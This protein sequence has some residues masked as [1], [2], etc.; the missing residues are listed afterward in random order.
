MAVA[1]LVLLMCGMRQKRQLTNHGNV[2]GF[3]SAM[4]LILLR[5]LE[6]ALLRD[7]DIV[8]GGVW[9]DGDP[10]VLV[11]VTHFSDT[12]MA[13]EEG[14]R[15]REESD[16]KKQESRERES[17][18]TGQK[19]GCPPRLS[20]PAGWEN[21]TAAGWYVHWHRCTADKQLVRFLRNLAIICPVAAQRSIGLTNVAGTR[22]AKCW[23]GLAWRC[24]HG[25]APRDKKTRRGCALGLPGQTR[26]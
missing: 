5:G 19:V 17:S 15:M 22:A 8:C 25:L 4:Q 24:K 6:D 14:E 16:R 1:T 12:R 2:T 20:W 21:C 7:A 9:R 18:N 10:V 11:V 23:G 26:P 3:E 13:E